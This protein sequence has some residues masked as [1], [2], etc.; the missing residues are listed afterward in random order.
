MFER[1]KHLVFAYAIRAY[2]WPLHRNAWSNVEEVT[3]MNLRYLE[4]P[5][6][7]CGSP[8]FLSL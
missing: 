5:N 4:L 1:L 7:H 2:R 6:L 8:L 3:R